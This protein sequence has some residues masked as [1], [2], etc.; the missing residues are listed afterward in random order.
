MNMIG[1]P[2]DRVDGVLKVTGR[3]RYA[4]DHS[5]PNLAHAVMVTST[6]ADGRIVAM[7]TGAAERM[8]GV[9]L[10]MTPFNAPRL[11]EGG[12]AAAG[13]PPAGR[14]LSLLQD[15]TVAYNNQPVAVVVADTQAQARDAASRVRVR[16]ERAGS[17]PVDFALDKATTHKP[18]KVKD[19]SADTQRGDMAAG[20]RAAAVR[21][22]AVYTTPMQNH[23]PME[24][25]ATIAVWEGDALTLYDSTQY[26]TGARKTVAKTLGIPPGKVRVV[27][28]FVGGG[29]GCKGSVWSHVVLAAMAA[30]RAGRPVKLAIERPQMFGEVGARPDTEQHFIAAAAADGQLQAMQHDVVAC[31]SYLEDWL[32]SSALMTR[33]LYDCPNQRTSHR[34]ARMHIG[35]PTFMRAPGEASGSFALESAMDELAYQLGMDPVALRLRNHAER[36]PGKDKPFS[37]KSLRECYRLG[38]ERFGWARRNPAPRSMMAD[39]KLVGMGMAT[40]TYPANRQAASAMVRILPDGTALVRSGSQDLGTGTYTVM[41]QVAAD[42]LGLPPQRVRF[43]LGDTDFPEAPVSGGSQ[44]VASV[45]PAVRAAALAARLE[46]AKL[47]MSD[48]ASPLYGAP[49][50]DIDIVDG[51]LLRRSAPERREPVAAPLARNGGKPVEVQMSA[52]PGDEKQ[53]FS[54]HSFGA[55]FA[56]VRVDPELGE[57]RVQ[58]IVGSYGVGRLLNRKTGRSQLMGGLVWGIGL[59]LLEKTEID[60]A[61]GRVANANLAEYHVPVNADVGSIEIIVVDEDDPHINSLGAKGIGEIGIVGV[62][63]A[64]ANAVY[65]ATGRRVRDLPVTLDKLMA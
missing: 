11:P 8:P 10:V 42:A 58:R 24:P 6:I 2:L 13:V 4:A 14:I 1:A 27:C 5:F 22:E 63:A 47:A 64:I 49:L 29:F 50:D 17:A 40:A 36:D 26:V 20:L 38:A 25:H 21:V 56:E 44:S 45:S 51:W 41:T 33:M 59:A 32:E 15:T 16:Y 55:V 3:A 57:I 62:G 23:N 65:H 19:E 54:M 52:R 35:T 46:L 12:K 39:G 37:S 28:P 34:L 30:Q 61:S 9:R 53:N 31:T 7:D 48:A 43:E 18:D 60:P